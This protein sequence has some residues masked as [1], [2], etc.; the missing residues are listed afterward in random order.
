MSDFLVIPA[1]ELRGGMALRYESVG[2]GTRANRV[3]PVGFARKFVEAGAK[4][5][6][7]FNLDGPFIVS[8]A[9]HAGSV[10]AGAERNL[11][12][13]G[14]MARTLNV[15]IQASGGIRDFESF[16]QVTK[17]GVQRA[18]MGSSA[19]DDPALVARCLQ[20]NP[21][22][23][24]VFLDVKAGRMVSQKWIDD[25]KATPA[26]VAGSIRD[27]GVKHFIYQDVAADAEGAGPRAGAA[28]GIAAAGCDVIVT[29]G[30]QTLDHIKAA[31]AVEGV[32]GVLVGKPLMT[33]EFTYE[34]AVAYAKA[35]LA[36][37]S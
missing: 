24:V 5:I 10:L 36:A 18:A 1:I 8:Q 26:Q 32:A 13:M 16:E 34:E 12:V 4:M 33:G 21:E 31:A 22:A 11:T 15:P 9:E 20:T 23:L 2:M 14:E 28:T 30:V 35:G 7:V 19:M 17:L 29:G 25:P 6:H 37:R 3:E 27:A